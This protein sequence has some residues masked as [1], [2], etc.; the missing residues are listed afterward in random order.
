MGGFFFFFFFSRLLQEC[1]KKYFVKQQCSAR[2]LM[3]EEWPGVC[4]VELDEVSHYTTIIQQPSNGAR[5]TS[6]RKGLQKTNLL[7]VALFK[8]ADWT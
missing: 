8:T 6:K 7:E 3:E 1:D 4:N 2:Q 5:S